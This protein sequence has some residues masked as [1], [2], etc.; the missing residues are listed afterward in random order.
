MKRFKDI[1]ELKNITENYVTKEKVY[2]VENFEPC[3]YCGSY[4]FIY[5]EDEEMEWYCDNCSKYIWEDD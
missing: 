2:I 4:N 3:K 1:G 5:E